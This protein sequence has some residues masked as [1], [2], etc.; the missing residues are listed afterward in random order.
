MSAKVTDNATQ[1]NQDHTMT[2]LLKF[3]VFLVLLIVPCYQAF[4]FKPT[5]KCLGK[6][7]VKGEHV[8]CEGELLPLTRPYGKCCGAKV[9][10][11][12]EEGC[13]DMEVFTRDPTEYSAP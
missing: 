12:P 13:K 6:E 11:P 1:L 2:G 3:A 4:F 5:L 9:F 7:Y 10:Y 8:C